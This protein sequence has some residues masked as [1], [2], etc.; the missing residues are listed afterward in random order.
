MSAMTLLSVFLLSIFP[1]EEEG[2]GQRLNCSFHLRERLFMT[3]GGVLP[4][5]LLG[6]LLRWIK[7]DVGESEKGLQ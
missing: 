7:N 6:S 1:F 2:M 5:R 4:A 3:P